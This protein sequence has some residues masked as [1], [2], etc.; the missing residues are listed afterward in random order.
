MTDKSM[1]E[2]LSVLRMRCKDLGI[3]LTEEQTRQFEI[4]YNC[5]VEKNK[6]MNLTAITQPME[7][8]EKHYL[9]SL[10]VV[11]HVDLSRAISVLDMGT[12]AGFPGIPLKIVFPHLHVT[13]ADSLNKRILFLDEV[14][15]ACG[16]TG[17]DTVHGRAED[18]GRNNNYREQYDLVV[19]R[20]VA[21][22]STLSEYCLPL[23]REEGLF[24]SYK[25]A[26]IEEEL[27]TA[28][29]AIRLLGGLQSR[30]EKDT[31]PGTALERSFVIIQKNQ[32]TPAKFPRKAGMPG[33]EPIC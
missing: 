14:I 27:K 4:Y 32:K 20:A 9:D 29:K 5:M 2:C 25:S 13:L 24:V 18:L 17:I 26:E 21:N 28:Q 11:R 3:V 23:V 33:K 7:V 1:N 31:I 15:D 19:S 22:L 6:V 30:V 8:V 12:G 10:L 16:L